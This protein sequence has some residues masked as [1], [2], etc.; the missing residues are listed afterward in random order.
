[1]ASIASAMGVEPTQI[2][3]FR[4]SVPSGVNDPKVAGK[5]AGGKKDGKVVLVKGD[6]GI[7]AYVINGTSVEKIPYDE[8]TYDSQFHQLFNPN[9]EQMLR[10]GKKIKNNI[11]K[12]EAGE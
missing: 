3:Q 9:L 10:G 11:Y 1:M 4:F 12:F 2:D 8:A 5:I 7:Y 6:D